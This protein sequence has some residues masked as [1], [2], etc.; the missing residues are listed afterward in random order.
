MRTCPA[1]TMRVSLHLAVFAFAACAF[2]CA[3]SAQ[4]PLASWNEGPAKRAIVAFVAHVT[5]TG[6]PTFVPPSQRIA[7]FD[8]DG[9][10]WPEQP[11]HRRVF[12]QV[13]PS[14]LNRS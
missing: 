1:S 10:L 4:E 6:M 3:V 5:A 9:T 7:G 2:A 14:T 13:H 12:T 8:N 11:S